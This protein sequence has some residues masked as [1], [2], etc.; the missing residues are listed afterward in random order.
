MMRQ[1]AGKKG[2]DAIFFFSIGHWRE[3][4]EPP[5]LKLLFDV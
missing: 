5:A 1:G 3:N 2:D 4:K